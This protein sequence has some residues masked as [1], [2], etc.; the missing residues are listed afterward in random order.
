M[1]HC[2]FCENFTYD[3]NDTD[4]VETK[5][6]TMKLLN[7]HIRLVHPDE[8]KPKPVPLPVEVSEPPMVSEVIV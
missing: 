7:D 2:P 6:N 8:D 1:Y 3:W 5:Q 4:S